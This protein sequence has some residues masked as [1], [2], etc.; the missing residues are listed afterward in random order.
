MGLLVS[1]AGVVA[2]LSES[3]PSLQ[4]YALEVLNDDV[5]NVWMEITGS[6]GVIEALYEDP[7]FAS[8]ELAVSFLKHTLLTAGITCGMQSADSTIHS[9]SCSLKDILASRRNPRK[10]DVR[11]SSWQAL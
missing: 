6:L 3:D 5:G 1:A 4:S 7:Q 9:G 8:R 2:L 10:H 11:I